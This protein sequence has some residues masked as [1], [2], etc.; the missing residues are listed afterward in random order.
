MSILI[1]SC[2]VWGTFVD[3]HVPTIRI[4]K[5]GLYECN[6]QFPQ[7][8]E[9][10]AII[11]FSIINESHYLMAPLVIDIISLVNITSYQYQLGHTMIS[12]RSIL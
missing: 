7:K 9:K 8:K 11:N 2:L 12:H 4:T 1:A 10:N 3:S 5:I 6:Y